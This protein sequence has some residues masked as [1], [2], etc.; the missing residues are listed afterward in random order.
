[1]FTGVKR[2]VALGCAVAEELQRRVSFRAVVGELLLQELRECLE[3]LGVRRAGGGQAEAVD[4]T[5][6]RC[7]A[8]FGDYSPGQ[9]AGRLDELLIVHQGQSLERSIGSWPPY[10]ASL[11]RRSIEHRKRR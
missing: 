7:V 9:V 2:F 1:V 6:L 8:S 5:L 11:A 10:R 4:K 3:F